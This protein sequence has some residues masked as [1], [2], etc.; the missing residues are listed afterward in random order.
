MVEMFF[1]PLFGT[2]QYGR[3][4]VSPHQIPDLLLSMHK[5]IDYVK[6]W[7]TANELKL[8]DHKTEAM[9]V[10]S[11]KKSRSLS[12]FFPGSMTIGCASV[13]VSDSVKN[14]G[15]TLHCHLT[16]KLCISSLVHLASF[17]LRRISSMH[18][19]LSTDDTFFFFFKSLPYC[20]SPPVWLSSASLKQTTKSSK[21]RCSPCPE[22]SPN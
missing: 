20:S 12:S 8:N 4:S 9:I 16:I 17:E 22:S 14:L 6:T 2:C 19:L 7:M 18:H 1:C 5:C 13:P 15:V 21:Q 10:S 11:G 3:P